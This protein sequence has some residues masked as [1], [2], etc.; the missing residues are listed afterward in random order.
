L[1][2]ELDADALDRILVARLMT[3]PELARASKLHP[4]TLSRARNGAAISP[5]TVRRIA[6]ALRVSASRLI[7]SAPPTRAAAVAAAG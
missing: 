6:A 3:V 1:T 7:V 2:V 5:A 4:N